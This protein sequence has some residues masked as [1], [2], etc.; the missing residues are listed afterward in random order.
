MISLGN[1]VERLH[2]R[3]AAFRTPVTSEKAFENVAAASSSLLIINIC[4]RIQFLICKQHFAE[5]RF[6]ERVDKHLRQQ[7]AAAFLIS[8]RTKLHV[9]GLSVLVNM[10]NL[11]YARRSEFPSAH[12]ARP[13]SMR[14]RPTQPHSAMNLRYDFT[15]TSE[16]EENKAHDDHQNEIFQ[17]R[18]V[19]RTIRFD[20]L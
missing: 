1:L 20:K 11:T 12:C 14:P 18:F 8:I 4:M 2:S 17:S 15:F 3:Q 5:N 13:S 9:C 10:E 19:T 16:Q 7:Q 6:S